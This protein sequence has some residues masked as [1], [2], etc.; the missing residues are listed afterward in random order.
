MFKEEEEVEQEEDV[1]EGFVAFM[2]VGLVVLMAARLWHPWW[3]VC[4]IQGGEICGIFGD[5][6]CGIHGGFFC[7]HGDDLNSKHY[8]SSGFSDF[9]C[10]PQHSHSQSSCR[11]YLHGWS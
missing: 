7:I 2:V 11:S 8:I 6:F 5:G 4:G 3:R 9:S 1:V 10:L